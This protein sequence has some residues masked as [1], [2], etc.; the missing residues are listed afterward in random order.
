MINTDP[1]QALRTTIVVSSAIIQ[2]VQV[3]VVII[4][5]GVVTGLA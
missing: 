5:V 3:V 1:N 4:G 2:L